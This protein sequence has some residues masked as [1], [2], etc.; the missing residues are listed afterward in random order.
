ML[1]DEQGPAH[2]KDFKIRLDLGTEHYHGT[3]T[4][5]KRAQHAAAEVAIGITKLVRPVE[6]CVRKDSLP[7]SLEKK[8]EYRILRE[9][10][11]AIMNE[12]VTNCH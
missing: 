6:K 3:G 2:K 5:I 1:V 10:V 11:L 7:L 12:R 8:S 9:S 4:S